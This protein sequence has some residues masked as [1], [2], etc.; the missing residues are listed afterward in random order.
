M[1]K[2]IAACS[3]FIGFIITQDNQ[4]Q[5]SSQGFLSRYDVKDFKYILEDFRIT[6]E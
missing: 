2:W 5:P 4:S 3:L 1:I 6:K